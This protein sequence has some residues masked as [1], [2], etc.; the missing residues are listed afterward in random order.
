MRRFRKSYVNSYVSIFLVVAFVMLPLH[1]ALAINYPTGDL[2]GD[3]IIDQ[4]D[5]FPLV[6]I[7]MER[8]DNFVTITKG[9]FNQDGQLDVADVVSILKYNGDWDNDG[10][11]DQDEPDYAFDPDIAGDDDNGIAD[12][13]ELD[14]DGDGFAEFTNPFRVDNDSPND[15]DGDEELDKYDEDDDNDGIK[16]IDEQIGWTNLPMPP[17]HDGGPF[18]T[19]S[20]LTDT[21]RDGLTDGQEQSLNTN[22]LH[23]DTDGDGILDG[24][25]SSPLNA[26]VP[27]GV[28]ST[29]EKASLPA[30]LSSGYTSS[31]RGLGF[32]GPEAVG[33]SFESVQSDLFSGAFS[34]SIPIKVPP[35]RN[36]MQPN[37]ALFYRSTNSHSWLGVGWD[38]N[39]GRIER[40]TKHGPPTY[41][42][43]S[44]PGSSPDTYIYATAAGGTQLVFTGTETIDQKTCGI[45]HA[46]IDSGSFVR[47]IHHPD[48]AHPARGY[49]EAWMK[50][51][52][53][54]WFGKD[55]SSQGAVGS[56]DSVITHPLSNNG[57]FSWALEREEDLNGNA[58]VYSY[59]HPGTTNDY[60]TGNNN[61]YLDQIKY[62]FI[63]STPNTIIDFEIAN[64]DD[65]GILAS[66]RESFRSK[67]RIV[68]DH[69]LTSINET[70]N[71]RVR[72]YKLFY[73]QLNLSKGVT[74]SCLKEVQEFGKTDGDSFLPVQL[75]YSENN[76]A[77]NIT[78]D[79]FIPPNEVWF[80]ELAGPEPGYVARDLGTRIMDI[81]GDGLSDL[82]RNTNSISLEEHFALNTG[83]GFELSTDY[84]FLIDFEF[85]VDSYEDNGIRI[86]DVNNDGRPDLIMNRIF[87]T[88]DPDGVVVSHWRDTAIHTGNTFEVVASFQPPEEVPFVYSEAGFEGITKDLGTRIID[89]NGDGYLDFMRYTSGD[90]PADNIFKLVRNTESSFELLSDT[91]ANSYLPPVPL[92]FT[93]NEKGAGSRIMDFNGDGL[94]EIVKPAN[95]S[96]CNHGSGF[97][98]VGDLIPSSLDIPFLDSQNQDAGSRIVDINGDGLSDVIRNI[99][100]GSNGL[101][102]KIALNSGNSFQSST[103]ISLPAELIFVNLVSESPWVKVDQGTRII[104]LNGD[105]LPDFLNHRFD[106]YI[107]TESKAALNTGAIPNL[108]T[109]IDNGIGGTVDIEYTPQTKGFMK[110]YDPKTDEVEVNDKIHYVLQVA[111]KIIRTTGTESYTTLYRYSGGKHIDKEF[112]GFGKAKTIDAQTGNFTITEFHQDYSRKGRVKSVRSYVGDRRD[113][114]EGATINGSLKK[115]A[116]E[117]APAYDPKL[118]SETYSRYRIVIHEDDPMYLK[119][120]TDTNTKLGIDDFPKGIT[121]V[122]PACT[123]TKIYEYSSDYTKSASE[124][125]SLVTAQ[126]H[127][128]DGRGNLI[129]TVNYGKVTLVKEDLDQPSI[130]ATFDAS[131]G[132]TDGRVNTM[133]KYEKRGDWTDVP[134]ITNTSGFYTA[135]LNTGTRETQQTRILEAKTIDY[136]LLNRPV[137]VTYS[138]NSGPDPAIEYEYDQFGNVT[139]IKDPLGN[140]TTTTYDSNLYTF[141]ATV[142]NALGHVESYVFDSGF[143]ILLSHTDAN[144]RTRTAEYDGLGRITVRKNSTGDT[145]TSH[146]YGFVPNFIR[147]TTHTPTGNV[148]KEDHF[149]GLGRIFET[150][151]VGQRGQA[152]PTRIVHVFNDRGDVWKT[153]SPHWSS[154]SGSEHWA[155]SIL[156]NDDPVNP[157][158]MWARMGL[159]RPLK[160]WSELN[161]AGDMKRTEYVYETPLST[162][163]I[164]LNSTINTERRVVMDAFGFR[165]GVWE[166]NASGNVGTYPVLQGQFTRYGH[167]ALGRLEFV[168]RHVASNQDQDADPITNIFYDTLGRKIKMDD[169]DSGLSLYGYDASGNLTRSVDAR[170]VEVIRQ[171]D[172][173]NRL[174]RTAYPD[175]ATGSLLEH[176][177]TYDTGDGSNLVGRLDKVTSPAS[178]TTYSY[179]QE[180]R[181]DRVQRVIDGVTHETTSQY[182]YGGR[183]LLMIYPNG[184]RLQYGYDT[185]TQSLKTITDPDTGQTW[186]SDLQMNQF[187][188]N[189]VMTL[190]NGVKRT[191][192]FDYA[193]R[194]T[195]LLTE[196]VTESGTTT[197]SELNYT[198]DLK[199]HITNIQETAGPTPKGDMQYQYDALDRLIQAWGTTMSGAD[200]GSQAAPAY[201]YSYDVLGR[202]ISNNRFLNST[203]SDYTLEYEYS[204]NPNSVKPAHAVRSIRFK[205]DG[206]PDAYAHQFN[207]DS[208][209]NLV[210]STN[211]AAALPGNDIART[212][213]WDALGRLQSVLKGT[214]TWNFVYDHAN[215]RI[216]KTSTSGESVTYIG[217]IAEVT[218]QGVVKHIFA[219]A[220]RI[221]TVKPTGEKLFYMTD[222]L[223]SSTLITDGSGIEI[224]RM[225]YEPYG[226]MI[227]NARSSN[228]AGLRHTYTGQEADFGTGLMY[229]NARYYDPIIATFISADSIVPGPSSPQSFNRYSYVLNN[230]VIYIDPTGHFSLNPVN[231][232]KDTV[233][234]AKNTYKAAREGNIKQLIITAAVITAAVYTGGAA[235]AW[236]GPM[237]SA[238]AGSLGGSILAGAVTGAVSGAAAGAAAGFVGGFGSSILSG[239]SFGESLFAGNRGAFKGAI[240]GAVTGAV[241]GAGAGA[242]KYLN[243]PDS[244][245]ST[246]QNTNAQQRT[247]HESNLPSGKSDQAS[248]EDFNKATDIIRKDPIYLDPQA[249]PN[250]TTI[251]IDH[252]SKSIGSRNLPASPDWWG[253]AKSWWNPL[254]YNPITGPE[255]LAV[256]LAVKFIFQ[257]Q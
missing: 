13:F 2:N 102:Q 40:S 147:T 255:T 252:F 110:L 141:P 229:Y 19:D 209:G 222:H 213:T 215:D 246:P 204:T 156:E 245:A 158:G 216:K 51:G 29:Q 80:I 161:S 88:L 71:G 177:Y 135:N 155:Y 73:K 93:W 208:V 14:T 48:P 206:S 120:F 18:I 185:A 159:N 189:R 55:Q 199:S 172:Q 136:D 188:S 122:T 64:Q 121:L 20:L 169:P 124:V 76:V 79:S 5:V 201:Q 131:V 145:I 170:G 193:G 25:D 173:L 97:F 107:G 46:E 176:V 95:S 184:M 23:P 52:R 137:R 7:I 16:D 167:D 223:R 242:Y 91:E 187:G 200:A 68:Y 117:A 118:V 227:E 109:G 87:E 250:Q 77:W 218:S 174:S 50:S 183:K 248:L 63:G 70:V 134:V 219:G 116:D 41:D 60:L 160:T 139:K 26:S 226:A 132:D 10:V 182:D 67:M 217:D 153:S 133:T 125:P 239:R 164:H 152:D 211:G 28:A 114:R 146:Q 21:D 11:L 75:T 236:M 205:K 99:D 17:Y 254:L 105:G 69:F 6:D 244:I 89:F 210:Q 225:D 190:G 143:G 86:G 221:A 163:S 56:D 82:V 12:A 101:I 251:D 241:I 130:D 81:N 144:N 1:S 166:P 212:N 9:D 27:S 94:P 53:K 191:V 106:T 129:Q 35:G 207:Y 111:S 30:A 42:N 128:F 126:E 44:A 162:K 142:T 4:T 96:I 249:N 112:R 238:Y 228:T 78:T 253:Y 181:A 37:I 92:H 119:T 194:A 196:S 165:T 34:Y 138:L 192:T 47:F 66:Y 36:G 61:M 157:T 233:D 203:F 231:W 62:N 257:T 178:A 198:F 247:S 43:P 220:L 54:A 243:R 57:V 33:A 224:Q 179:D 32:Q 230:P 237:M 256:K 45:Y 65:R 98:D 3:G 49:W 234:F 115:A 140:T 22:P 85:V 83:T 72:K 214:D 24:D 8:N 235:A 171:Y 197:L 195:H 168:R 58:I 31:G 90:D 202:M 84:N 100:E 154:E 15:S 127:F 232:V 103:E 39:P 151:A 149:D 186:L 148:W 240:G 113:Y 150:L 108:L 74:I 180:G 104:D 59:Q 175:M 123:L 38:L